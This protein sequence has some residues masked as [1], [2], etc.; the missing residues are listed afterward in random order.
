M[1][2]LKNIYFLIQKRVHHHHTCF[3]I[4]FP[5]LH[6]MSLKKK[7]R[8]MHTIC[9][10]LNFIDK[11]RFMKAYLNWLVNDLSDKIC[12]QTFKRCKTPKDYR[13]CY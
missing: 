13:E 2:T 12:C 1:K 9:H 10:S 6:E 3:N 8:V 11:A 7:I 5:C 4:C